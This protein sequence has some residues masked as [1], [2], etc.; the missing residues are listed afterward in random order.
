ML[1]SFTVKFY[2]TI[3]WVFLL[4][5]N[6][7]HGLNL[8]L[9]IYSQPLNYSFYPLNLR[10][11]YKMHNL[12]IFYTKITFKV[13]PRIASAHLFYAQAQVSIQSVKD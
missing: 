9:I 3:E 8:G 13:P 10:N 5:S 7:I 11:D 12:N 1:A 2:L 6:P 4:S